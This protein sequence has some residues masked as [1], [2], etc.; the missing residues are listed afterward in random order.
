MAGAMAGTNQHLA[1]LFQQMAEVM[2]ILD[3]DRFRI[4]AFARAARVL[5]DLHEDV[6]EIGPDPKE[7]AKV[8]GIGKGT[9]ERIAEFIE[10]GRIEDHE[11]LMGQIPEGL[12]DLLDIPSLGP[13][14]IALLWK[15]AG[16]D[17]MEALKSKLAGDV[18]ADLPGLGKKKLEN[19]RKSIAFADSA[20]DRVRIGQAMPLAV[21]LV[22]VLETLDPVVEVTYAG[23]LRRGR[24]TIGDLDI[25]VAADPRHASVISDAFVSFEPVT[26]VLIKGLTKTSVRM[27]GSIQ[28]DLRIVSPDQYGAALMYFT[29]SKEHNITMRQRAIDRGMRLNEYGLLKDDQTVAGK[30]E[31]DV[32]KALGL[33]WIPPE[34]REDRGELGQ[35]ERNDLPDLVEMDDIKSELHAHTNASDGRWSIRELGL[36]AAERG[37]HTVAITDHSKGQAQANGLTEARLEKHIEEIRKV[38]EELAGT[39]QIL[40]GTEVDILVDGKLDYPD[41]L[42]EAL[43]VVVASPHA[44]LSQDPGKA[45]ARLLR[46][47]ENPFVTIL[48]HPTGRLINRREGMVPDMNKVVTAAAARGIALEI[49]ANSW[50]LDLRDTHARAVVDASVKLAINTDAH[51]PGDLDELFY[52]VLTARR[53][54]AAESDVVNCLSQ[55]ELMAWLASTRG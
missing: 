37:F 7:L 20:G 48:G 53:A 19:L 44:A 11:Q 26:E 15:Q 10:T 29:G 1:V 30:T 40:A 36:A 3:K 35:A 46:A 43:D 32:F 18:L 22:E 55:D 5:G 23:S 38:Q 34:L 52:G 28:A 12:I 13:K 31:E 49:N 6:A 4:N 41:S 2:Q 24:E 8:E 54:G 50:R 42:L 21:H 17:G 47:I 39:I 27:G 14:T 9:A 25:I 51:G 16:V 33:A 45:T